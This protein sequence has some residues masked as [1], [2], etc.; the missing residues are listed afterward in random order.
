MHSFEETDGPLLDM[1]PLHLLA[2]RTEVNME[3][4]ELFVT[5][6]ADANAKNLDG[7]CMLSFP[8]CTYLQFGSMVEPQS[9]TIRGQFSC[10]KSDSTTLYLWARL[11]PNPKIKVSSTFM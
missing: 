6:G 5:R 11:M 4:W 1:T 10:L 2:N 9:R 8:R 3:L 7:V